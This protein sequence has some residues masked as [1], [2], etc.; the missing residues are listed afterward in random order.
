MKLLEDRILQEGVVLNNSILKVDSFLNY[1]IDMKV[2]KAVAHF[3]A[4]HFQNVDKVIT[5]EASG[6]AFAVAVAMELGDVPIVFAKK[7][8]TAVTASDH[9]YSYT[10]HSFTHNTD[11]NIYIA[12]DFLKP[13]ERV[14]IVDDF[15]AAGES[16]VGLIKMCLQAKAIPLGV[17]VACEKEMQGGRK[18]LEELGVKVCACARITGF[19]NNRPIFSKEEC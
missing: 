7:S 1:Q 3:I 14:L 10:V 16:S 19:S 8:K 11:N 6:I 5:I 2:L 9:N 15:L 13:G 4:Q 17:A 12:Q 18:R